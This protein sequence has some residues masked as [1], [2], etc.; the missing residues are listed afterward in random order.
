MSSKCPPYAHIRIETVLEIAARTRSLAAVL[1]YILLRART[2][3]PQQGWNLTIEQLLGDLHGL[4]SRRSVQRSLASLEQ[5]SFIERRRRGRAAGGRVVSAGPGAREIG[6]R[7]YA[8]ESPIPLAERWCLFPRSSFRPENCAPGYAPVSTMV[9]ARGI[10]AR[11]VSGHQPDRVRTLTGSCPD[12]TNQQAIIDICA[13]AGVDLPNAVAAAQA[14]EKSLPDAAPPPGENASGASRMSPPIQNQEERNFPSKVSPASGRPERE[15]EI[16]PPSPTPIASTVPTKPATALE[17]ELGDFG[18]GEGSTEVIGYRGRRRAV[19]MDMVDL[20]VRE[21]YA[22]V[23]S[24]GDPRWIAACED[25]CESF[26]LQIRQRLRNLRQ[27]KEY[28]GTLCK[29]TIRRGLKRVWRLCGHQLPSLAADPLAGSPLRTYIKGLEQMRVPTILEG[30]RAALM[31]VAMRCSE[32][33]KARALEEEELAPQLQPQISSFYEAAWRQLDELRAGLLQEAADQL[34]VL[35]GHLGAE[36]LD[37]GIQDVARERMRAL[38]PAASLK[39]LLPDAY[40]TL[41]HAGAMA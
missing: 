30:A 15:E 24:D 22:P 40:L 17:G 33:L 8:P 34:D 19:T 29:R 14:V 18:L 20:L 26:V 31:R 13:P 11:I 1:V 38:F 21:V 35:R 32:A 2:N 3:N 37:R 4:Y 25:P 39:G 5:E 28:S 41:Q 27:R 36:E 6:S 7:F 9:C 12:I 16:S 10:D 23:D